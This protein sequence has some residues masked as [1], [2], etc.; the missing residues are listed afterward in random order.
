MQ[1]KADSRVQATCASCGGDPGGLLWEG[2][3]LLGLLSVNDLVTL[4]HGA[5]DHRTITR[6]FRT[7]Q[8]HG[9]KLGKRWV[10]RASQFIADWDK[11]ERAGG[12]SFSRKI[13]RNQRVITVVA[14]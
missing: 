12:I 6:L 2:F 9:T 11:L 5:L 4:F 1:D 13:A 10:I 14:R 3:V 8:F 7:G